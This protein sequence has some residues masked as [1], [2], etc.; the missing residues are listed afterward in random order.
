MTM[1]RKNAIPQRGPRQ[2]S[3]RGETILKMSP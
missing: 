3:N 2:S 1:M